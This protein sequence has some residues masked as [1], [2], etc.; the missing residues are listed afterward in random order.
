MVSQSAVNHTKGTMPPP[1]PSSGK[2]ASL[3]HLPG[4]FSRVLVLLDRESITRPRVRVK[5]HRRYEMSLYP[6]KKDRKT[7]TFFRHRETFPRPLW[8]SFLGTFVIRL[9]K[10]SSKD[11]TYDGSNMDCLKQNNNY[12][13]AYD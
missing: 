4:I 11:F 10:Y 2:P 6:A 9:G 8:N 12:D 13:L 7:A 5:D 1:P 3:N